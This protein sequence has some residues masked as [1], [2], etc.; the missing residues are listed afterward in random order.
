MSA[1]SG[2]FDP[3]AYDARRGGGRTARGGAR[4][5][6]IRLSLSYAVTVP[7]GPRVAIPLRPLVDRAAG[8]GLAR[9]PVVLGMFAVH[10]GPDAD[11]SVDG[12]KPPDAARPPDGT[13]G[14]R[15]THTIRH[16]SRAS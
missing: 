11:P 5:A 6:G 16:P 7:F 10:I 15:R 1:A 4:S 9:C 2:V 14:R 12:R 3:G 13:R 8:L